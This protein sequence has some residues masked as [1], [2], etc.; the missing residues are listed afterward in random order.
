[1]AGCIGIGNNKEYQ[2]EE[3]TDKVKIINPSVVK[4]LTVT[5]CTC[6]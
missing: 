3:P 2:I 1:M 6:V 5:E 4:I